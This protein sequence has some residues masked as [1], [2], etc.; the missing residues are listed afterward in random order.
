MS[1]LVPSA[2]D[3]HSERGGKGDPTGGLYERALA[4]F[5]AQI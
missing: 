3:I 1:D 5:I 4:S 2:G